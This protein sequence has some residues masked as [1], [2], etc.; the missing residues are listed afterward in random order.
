MTPKEVIEELEYSKKLS[1]KPKSRRGGD[2]R[3]AL[4]QAIALIKQINKLDD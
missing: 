4:S 1:L 3:I 2:Y